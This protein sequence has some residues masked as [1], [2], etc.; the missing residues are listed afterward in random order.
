VPPG[1][2]QAAPVPP[3][4][5]KAAVNAR[6]RAI[7]QRYKAIAN[8]QQSAELIAANKAFFAVYT[9]C[10]DLATAGNYTA[11]LAQLGAVEAALTA[12]ETLV[13]DLP[14]KVKAASDCAAKLKT[15]KDADLKKLSAA[16]RAKLVQTLL[17]A[18][19]P[20]GE[21]RAAQIRLYQTTELDKKFM[22][23][24][25][26]RGKA[27]AKDLKGD[28]ELK[29]ARSGW[30]AASEADKIKALKKV[31]A[32]QSK[33]L[34]IPPP[35]LVIE[36]KP[37]ANGLVTNGY[38]SPADGKLHINMDPASSVQNFQR[39]V[40]LALH[41]NAHNWQAHLVEDLKAGKLKP[42]DTNYDQA[43]MFAVNEIHPGGYITGEEDYDA[44]KKQPLEDH[45]WTTGPA[46]ARKIM[47]GL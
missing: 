47:K 42:G 28:K 33:V 8:P 1:P 16:D 9:P 23:A 41:E 35:E 6:L 44:Y 25:E 11:A 39:A 46:T 5:N 7:V 3:D 15:R 24:D 38:F 32:S 4:P 40:D 45:S 31:V 12:L 37:P 20:T 30:K 2:A 14:N 13:A 43:L 10:N 29:A 22:K 18:G 19:K 36:H 17:G 27:I 26:D 21:A 34:G